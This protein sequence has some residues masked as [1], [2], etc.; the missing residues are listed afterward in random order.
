MRK[1]DIVLLLIRVSRLIHRLAHLFEK[2]VAA[3]MIERKKKEVLRALVL[4]PMVVLTRNV[5]IAFTVKTKIS[6]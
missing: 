6:K 3:L 4:V 2:H 1:D 5:T